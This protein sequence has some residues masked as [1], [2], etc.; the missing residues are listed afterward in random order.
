MSL[1]FDHEQVVGY[2]ILGIALDE[3]ELYVIGVA[4]AYQ[5]LGWGQELLAQLLEVAVQR[6]VRTVWL[7]VR[8]NNQAA[9]TLYEHVHFRRSGMRRD[10]YGRGIHAYVYRKELL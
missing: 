4:Q 2:A 5:H 1:S 10:Y 7:E 9:I 8:T 3:A 6:N